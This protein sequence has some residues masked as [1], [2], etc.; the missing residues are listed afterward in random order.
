MGRRK[1]PYQL[2]PT[3]TFPLNCKMC[4]A[5]VGSRWICMRCAMTS[6]VG[7][8]IRKVNIALLVVI[9]KKSVQWVID[10]LDGGIVKRNVDI[11][12]VSWPWWSFPE[13]GLVRLSY[14]VCSFFT[15]LLYILHT[16]QLTH[17]GWK[18]TLFYN[19]E[20]NFPIYFK[21]GE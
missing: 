8:E 15:N 7:Y 2:R 11:F 1:F 19:H 6:P 16:L 17:E 5:D 18:T 10:T 9:R 13:S 20:D 3:W 4:G 14:S 21:R 12:A